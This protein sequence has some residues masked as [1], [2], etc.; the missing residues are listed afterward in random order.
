MELATAN[1]V[2]RHDYSDSRTAVGKLVF[3][4]PVRP[5]MQFA[6][7]QL[8]TQVMNPTSESTRAVETTTRNLKGTHNTCLRI[9]SHNSVQNGMI[10][11]VGRSVSD[12]AGH[13]ATRQS[14]TGYHCNVQGVMYCNSS[15][16]QTAICLSSC[17]AEFYAASVSAG[18][19]V[20]LA[21]LFAELHY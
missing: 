8:S 7:Q 15:L 9:E 6:I 5:E 14:G 16:K 1:R 18:E 11:L 4:A 20:G 13:S 2:D 10:E 3:M 17:E 21:E 19:L 12:W